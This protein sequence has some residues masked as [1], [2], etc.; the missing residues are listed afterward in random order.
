[1]NRAEKLTVLHRLKLGVQL[2]ALTTEGALDC[3]Y[4]TSKGFFH[5]WLALDGDWPYYKLQNINCDKLEE[6][7]KKVKQQALTFEDLENTELK[8][9]YSCEMGENPD[10]LNT[11]FENII[12]VS[13]CD[14]GSLYVFVDDGVSYFFEK[15]S[16]FENA[17]EDRVDNLWEDLSDDDLEE[18]VEIVS[19]EETTF[20]FSEF[21]E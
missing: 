2:I 14:D 10:T 4:I 8:D 19:T 21:E 7:K 17:M 6:I 11:F 13:F 1:M 18:W 9:L 5:E 20:H 16:A 12:S 15:Y 3:T